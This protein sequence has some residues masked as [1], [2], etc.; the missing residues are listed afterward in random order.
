LTSMT[1]CWYPYNA[2]QCTAGVE[3]KCLGLCPASSC[4]LI[5]V[6]DGPRILV[7]APLEP[8]GMKSFPVCVCLTKL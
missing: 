5:D 8:S 6:D 7:D 1:A 3:V 4:L 2:K